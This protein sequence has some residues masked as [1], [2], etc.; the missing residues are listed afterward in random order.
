MQ[1]AFDTIRAIGFFLHLAARFDPLTQQTN[2]I[3]LLLN[4]KLLICY[5]VWLALHCLSWHTLALFLGHHARIG[6]GPDDPTLLP[7]R[8]VILWITVNFLRC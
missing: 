6:C 2:N 8:L 1:R 3:S 4:H 7:L 5:S